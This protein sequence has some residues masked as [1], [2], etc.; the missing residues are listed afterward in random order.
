MPWKK[1]LNTAVI[2]HGICCLHLSNAFA[3]TKTMTHVVGVLLKPTGSSTCS[4]STSN[5]L[6]HQNKEDPRS[7]GGNVPKSINNTTNQRGNNGTNQSRNSN[8]NKNGKNTSRNQNPTEKRLETSLGNLFDISQGSSTSTSTSKY[9]PTQDGDIDIYESMSSSTRTPRTGTSMEPQDDAPLLDESMYLNSEQYMDEDGSF[10]G[11]KNSQL[12]NDMQKLLVTLMND[13]PGIPQDDEFTQ[14]YGFNT[15]TDT[16]NGRASASASASMPEGNTVDDQALLESIISQNNAKANTSIDGEE[17]HKRVFANEKG[18]LQ[19]S[20][21]FRESLVPDPDQEKKHEAAVLRRG[22]EYRKQQ[23]ET[24]KHMFEEMDEFERSIL[25]REDA[26]KLAAER[27]TNVANGRMDDDGTID[28]GGESELDLDPT[29]ILCSKCSCLL[30]AEEVI[31]ERKKGRPNPSEM[32]CR[33]CQV[34]SMQMKKGSPYLMGRLGRN[35]KFPPRMGIPS[36][37]QNR[38]VRRKIEQIRKI[39][40]RND[41]GNED[42]HSSSNSNSDDAVP[43]EN[44]KRTRTE[45]QSNAWREQYTNAM[46]QQRG[47]LMRGAPTS[48]SASPS[49]STSTSTSSMTN[50]T[51]TLSNGNDRGN[52]GSTIN[53]NQIHRYSNRPQEL[54][55]KKDTYAD[56]SVWNA[57]F[58]AATHRRQG[59]EHTGVAY[60]SKS[61]S[62]GNTSTSMNTSTST[63]TNANTNN[64]TTNSQ[65]NQGKDAEAKANTKA[66]AEIKNLRGQINNLLET[67]EDYKGQQ[68]KSSK[69]I[70]ALQSVM[71]GMKKTINRP[72]KRKPTPWNTRTGTGTVAASDTSAVAS[73]GADEEGNDARSKVVKEVGEGIV[74]GIGQRHRQ[75]QPMPRRP[76]ERLRQDVDHDEIYLD[77][78]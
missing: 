46:S 18:F 6:L 4:S 73:T 19:Q 37:P 48:T 9:Y 76:V 63:N 52:T 62:I 11:Q 77:D 25:S 71:E 26:K 10:V 78:P 69:Q 57:H 41:D 5:T 8:Q 65:N 20:E 31:F 47:V 30:S 38:I 75:S 56:E 15:D 51:N 13:H 39:G 29:T 45:A 60:K 58:K 72:V 1:C 44:G 33:L 34:D 24:L 3:P 40:P 27:T 28:V 17:L 67:I 70:I 49:A 16:N 66:E 2:L 74:R 14:E 68:E 64:A 7:Y 23:E 36:P 61:T 59:I 42:I 12:D 50:G 22:T 32:I 43:K 54:K 35:G 53:D 21:L 55:M